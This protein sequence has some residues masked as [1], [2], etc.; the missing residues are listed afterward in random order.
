[1]LFLNIL[2]GNF[3]HFYFSDEYTSDLY[4]ESSKS[5]HKFIF[6]SLAQKKSCIFTRTKL[7]EFIH[8]TEKHAHF[9]DDFCFINYSIKNKFRNKLKDSNIASFDILMGCLKN[10]P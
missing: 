6:A 7:T 8:R 1:M 10:L 9:E 3:F 2:D 4:I 5:I